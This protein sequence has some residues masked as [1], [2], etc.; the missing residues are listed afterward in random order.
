MVSYGDAKKNGK[1]LRKMWFLMTALR[2]MVKHLGSSKTLGKIWFLM[3]ML[4]KVVKN[5]GNMG[6]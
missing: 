1:T 6:F 5:L 4:R 3:A 2:K